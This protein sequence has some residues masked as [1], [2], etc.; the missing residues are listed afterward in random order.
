MNILTS[1]YA[2][3]MYFWGV[4]FCV[5]SLIQCFRER[6]RV[7][8]FRQDLGPVRPPHLLHLVAH[9][10]I[11]KNW[12]ASYVSVFIRKKILNSSLLSSKSSE[13]NPWCR[14]SCFS[15]SHGFIQHFLLLVFETLCFL[16]YII[17]CEH[18]ATTQRAPICF[19]SVSLLLPILFTSCCSPLLY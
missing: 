15:A 4:L 2:L 17:I 16:L 9:L 19:L 14:L 5:G 3:K 7:Q 12:L 1:S 10:L 11:N 13:T 18:A 6:I 8:T